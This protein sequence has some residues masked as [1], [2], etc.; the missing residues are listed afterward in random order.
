M[1]YQVTFK[2]ALG[3]SVFFM[4]KNKIQEGEV[5]NCQFNESPEEVTITYRVQFPDSEKDNYPMT[6]KILEELVFETKEDL[7][8]SL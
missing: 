8:A 7:L 2:F 1:A 6:E 4:H 3:D 5:K